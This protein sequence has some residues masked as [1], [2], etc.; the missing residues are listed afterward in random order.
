[1]DIII[2][3]FA[4]A[5]LFIMS[6]VMYLFLVGSVFPRFLLKTRYC[7]SETS[8]R[9]LNKFR[10]P[11]G[12]AVV[13]EPHPS[14]RKYINKYLLFTNNGYKYIKCKTDEYVTRLK[15]N[16][17]LFNNKNRIIDVVCV[18]ESI[19][20]IGETAPVMLHH[21][22]SYVRL[23]LLSVNN[24]VFEQGP[25]VYYKGTDAILYTLSGVL[26]SFLEMTFFM[27]TLSSL[28]E[29]LSVKNATNTVSSLTVFLLASAI[30]VFFCAIVLLIQHSKGIKVIWNAKKQ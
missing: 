22:T 23:D 10:Y 28:L 5:I 16:V 27:S 13:Y 30:G 8:D 4:G 21:N 7:N 17:V 12:R 9:G 1:M 11:Q 25:L 26:A 15:Y 19:S 18:D 14:V 29:I 3:I 20:K 2:Q 24:D 6:I